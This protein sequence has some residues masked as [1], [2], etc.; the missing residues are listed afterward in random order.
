MS[1]FILIFESNTSN[2][3]IT[4]NIMKGGHLGAPKSLII[5]MQTDGY[6]SLFL[7]S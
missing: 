2:L 1:I 7:S 6:L 5:W 3:N 4:N